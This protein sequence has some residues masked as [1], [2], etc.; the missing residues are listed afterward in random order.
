MYDH[1]KIGMNNIG[2][3]KAEGEVKLNLLFTSVSAKRGIC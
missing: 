1:D 3:I 2:V